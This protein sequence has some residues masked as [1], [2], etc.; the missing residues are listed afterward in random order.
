MDTLSD[1]YSVVV[2]IQKDMFLYSVPNQ[3]V[4]LHEI[5]DLCLHPWFFVMFQKI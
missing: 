2:V 3:F 4:W 5:G 1:M